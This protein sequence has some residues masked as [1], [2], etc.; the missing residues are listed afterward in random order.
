MLSMKRHIVS[1]KITDTYLLNNKCFICGERGCCMTKKTHNNFN[2]NE[3][4]CRSK[5][6]RVQVKDGNLKF[7]TRNRWEAGTGS[8]ILYLEEEV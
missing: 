5:D 6:I 8:L 1:D 7:N 3:I 4:W 2:V